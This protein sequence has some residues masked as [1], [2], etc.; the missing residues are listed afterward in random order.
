MTED[1]IAMLDDI[2]RKNAYAIMRT[3]RRSKDLIR[4]EKRWATNE[5]PRHCEIAQAK[6]EINQRVEELLKHLQGVLKEVR[7]E[8]QSL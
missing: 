6:L 7:H 5:S 1:A 2:I 3:E 8:L 4:I